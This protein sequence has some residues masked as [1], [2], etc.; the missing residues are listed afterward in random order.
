MELDPKLVAELSA[1]AKVQLRARMKA[2]RAAY[3]QGSLAERSA[4][5]VERVA[6]LPTFRAARSVGLFWPLLA[7]NEVDLRPLDALAREAKK[8]VYY[9]GFA[10][11]ADGALSTDLRLTGSIAELVPRGGRFAE[12]PEDAERAERGDVDLFVV[13][14]LAVALSGHRLGFGMGFYDAMLPDY[15]PPASAVVVAFDFQVL[16]ELPVEPHDIACDFVVSDARTV[17]VTK[18]GAAT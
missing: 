18:F 16:A 12:P 10:R 4:K 5:I 14:A 1:R 2:L 6:E 7:K 9:P 17:T 3:P 15:R 11:A 8:R 13:P